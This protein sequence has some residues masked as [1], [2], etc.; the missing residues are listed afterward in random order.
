[1]APSEARARLAAQQAQLLRTLTDGTTPPEGFQAAQVH[2]AAASLS[3]KRSRVAARAWPMLAQALGAA[4]EPRFAAFAA[5]TPLPQTGGPLADGR[6]FARWLARRGELPDEGRLEGL[7]VDLYHR[8][9]PAGLEHRRGPAVAVARLRTA[10]QVVVGV[11]IP[12]LGVWQL[13]VP[14]G[15]RAGPTSPAPLSND[16]KECV[17]S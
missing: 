5:A 2:A 7:G 6:S 4:F 15:R 16:S 3:R 1:M 10:R 8:R 9:T 14:L 12:G 17:T 13:T 11:R